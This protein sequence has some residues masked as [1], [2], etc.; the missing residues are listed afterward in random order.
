LKLV[1]A[2]AIMRPATASD[3]PRLATLQSV[4]AEATLNVLIDTV[5]SAEGEAVA[6]SER[7][8]LVGWVGMTDLLRAVR[9]SDH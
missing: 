4:D 5:L 1:H 3:L 2:R 9:G 7:G 6:I 8:V